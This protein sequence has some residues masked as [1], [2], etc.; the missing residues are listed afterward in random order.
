MEPNKSSHLPN[1]KVTVA[2][3]YCAGQKLHNPMSY[4]INPS[5]IIVDGMTALQG[6]G[7]YQE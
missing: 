2:G 6:V 5:S 7:G 3:V 4:Y 1:D